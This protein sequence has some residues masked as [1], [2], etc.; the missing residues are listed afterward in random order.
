MNKK[1]NDPKPEKKIV[2]NSI[3]NAADPK[4]KNMMIEEKG[5]EVGEDAAVLEI[6]K[7][8]QK[9]GD[10]Q[11][12]NKMIEEVYEDSQIYEGTK[13]DDFGLMGNGLGQNFLTETDV[14]FQQNQN[15]N[16]VLSD[17]EFARQLQ[18]EYNKLDTDNNVGP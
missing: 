3:C 11:N 18:D 4:K 12:N 9:P 1:T 17:E 16:P 8:Y 13:N 14:P 15:Q 6:L 5:Y 2:G 10:V 7:K